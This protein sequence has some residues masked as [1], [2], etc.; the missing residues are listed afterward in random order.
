MKRVLII[1]CGGAGKST[2]AIALGRTLG[3][4][5]HHLDR[6]FWRPGWIASESGEFEEAIRKILINDAWIMDG[7]YGGSLPMRIGSA[8]TIIFLDLPTMTCLIGAFRR[9]WR[10]RGR[11][12]PD[13]TEG[14]VER[15][16][17]EFLNWILTYRRTRRPKI[18]ATL[19]Q[20]EKT[21]N[22]IGLQ[23]R[24]EIDEWLGRVEVEQRRSPGSDGLGTSR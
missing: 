4:P 22:I 15:I 7:N 5:V 23:S 21:R 9:F 13:M 14:N 20:L 18:L 19:A 11:S 8:D 24:A 6:L 12:R 17:P 3:I 16:N 2:L 10:Y 1:G